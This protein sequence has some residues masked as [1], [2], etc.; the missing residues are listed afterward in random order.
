MLPVLLEVGFIKIYTYGIF[1]ALAFFWSTYLFWKNIQ[2]TGY[3]ESELFDGFFISLIGAGITGRLLHVA[4]HFQDFGVNILRIVLP[5]GFPGFDVWGALVGF[6]VTFV[7]F[8][9][10]RKLK[11]NEVIDYLIPPVLLGLAIAKLGAFFAGSEIG[12]LTQYPVGIIYASVDG[13]RH[14]T[15]LY[16]SF[17]FFLAAFAAYRLLME[18]RRTNLTKGFLTPFFLFCYS[19][20]YL[21]TDWIRF[22]RYMV[23]DISLYMI[24]SLVLVL[25]T[26]GYFLYYFREN[27]T[28]ATVGRLQKRIKEQKKTKAQ[29]EESVT[30]TNTEDN[31]PQKKKKHDKPSDTGVHTKS[32]TKAS[33]NQSK[34]DTGD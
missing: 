10:S 16:E 28:K 17:L 11:S 15:P 18:V 29:K 5:N 2:L 20:I 34:A 9:R 33:R 13:T 19:F 8:C 7:L 25:T 30:S 26:T 24:V 23:S 32:E 12:T 27:I 22:D 31:K 14:L 4:L 21:V 1:L 3:K 6:F